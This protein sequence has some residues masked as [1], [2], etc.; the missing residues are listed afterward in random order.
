MYKRQTLDSASEGINGIIE[1]EELLKSTN[2]LIKDQGK[3]I[4]NM[5]KTMKEIMSDGNQSIETTIEDDKQNVETLNKI[6]E[7]VINDNKTEIEEIPNDEKNVKKKMAAFN[8]L[9][10]RLLNVPINTKDYKDEYNVIK[11]I[12]LRNGYNIEI[13]DKMIHKQLRKINGC[14]V[15]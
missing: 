10:Y 12:A 6:T 7:E 11:H 4:D 15:K 3:V 8:A 14:F 9:A 13:V 2:K 5:H 1:K